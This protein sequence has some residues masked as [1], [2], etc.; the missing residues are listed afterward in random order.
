[1]GKTF[2]FLLIVAVAFCVMGAGC[3]GTPVEPNPT[4]VPPAASPTCGD[5]AC[6]GGET[7]ASCNAD[8][9][10]CPPSCGDGACN[11][12]EN[13]TICPS[14]CGACVPK[15]PEANE[16]LPVTGCGDK[17][18]NAPDEN[19][20]SCPT[21]CSSASM[22]GPSIH[23]RSGNKVNLEV[24]F[25]VYNNGTADL[26]E[27]DLLKCEI[28]VNGENAAWFRKKVADESINP[29]TKIRVDK[30]GATSICL[31]A[32]NEAKETFPTCD[33]AY[34]D[35]RDRSFFPYDTP[36]EHMNIMF[37]NSVNG[38]TSSWEFWS[39]K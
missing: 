33:K 34:N 30:T 9:G 10:V 21:D 20:I 2:A 36:G 13:C 28:T 4:T 19:A 14:D 25:D 27:A 12:N 3:I 32:G 37:I 17:K 16:T 38:Q 1:M 31:C 24:C 11:G 5:G 18:C 39:S 29:F 23:I 7:C 26:Y 8:C 15:P 22:S 35:A 6:N